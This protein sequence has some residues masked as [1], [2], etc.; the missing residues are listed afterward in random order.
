MLSA[1]VQE[2]L[3]VAVQEVQ[4]R[5]HELLTVEHILFSLTTVAPGR[6]LLEG[7]GA[8]VAV[9]REQLEGF[10]RNEMQVLPDQGEHEVHQTAGVQRV[11]ERALGHIHA[12]GRSQVELG[13]LFVAIL[14]EEDSYAHYFLTR[15]G[16]DR[17][18]ALTFISHGMPEGGGSRGV[19]PDA[20][21]EKEE[22]E[23]GENVLEKYATELTAR[24]RDGKIDPLV[25]RQEELDR[26]IEVLCRR[27]KNNPLF[28]G[29]P[30]VGK[31]AL[32]EGLALR[33]AQGQVPKKF[34]DVK[35]Y[36]LDMGLILAGTRYRGEFESRLKAIVEEL[37][38]IPDAV[39][40]ID[41]IHTIVGAGATS[42]GSM[43]ASNLLK[44]VLAS[45]EL[46][47]IGSTTHEEFRNHLEKDRALT[48]RFQRIDVGEPNA[49]DCFAI[50]NGLQ[51]HYAGHH[52]VRYSETV[53]RSIVDLSNRYVRDRLQP[54][55]AIDV[56]D[57]VGAA[58]DLRRK[59]EKRTA[60][61][62]VS[63]VERIVARMAGV[64]VRTVSGQERN[65]L[66]N[67]EKNLKQ[68]VF[69]QE[70]AVEQTV[71]AILRS[72]A[73]LGQRQRPTGA[74][75]F[76]G[77]TGV[78]KTE[79]ARGLAQTMGVEFLRYDMSEYME[80]H[81]VSRLI[82]SPPGY[83]GFD[84]GGLLTEAVRKA[85]YSVVLLDEIEKAHPD[86]FNILLQV[87]DYGTLTD[88]SGRKTDFSH[89]V[90]IMTSNAGTFE[91]S[92]AS[93]GFGKAAPEDAARKALGAVE[94][95]FTPEFR[96]R[97]D[98]MIPFRALTPAMM[99]RI[100]DK[101]LREIGNSLAEQQVTLASTPRAR[102]WLAEKGYDP[103]MGARPLRRLLR[104]RVEDALAGELLFGH[105]RHGGLVRLGVKDNELVLQFPDA[106]PAQG[107]EA[108]EG[109]DGRKDA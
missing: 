79:L 97:L 12:S 108:E 40:F 43:D 80:P 51:T 66:A 81:T 1:A 22:G 82:G 62:T 27:R 13:D 2:V 105:L 72:R 107:A 39:V 11:L 71:R 84:Q 6:L 67:L 41:E 32:A 98:A 48:R 18:D 16:V 95:L 47:C 55:K 57:E 3:K 65:R 9:L 75:L 60:A 89:T 92:K 59:D 45:G 52:R 37:K 83:V 34:K 69:G 63:D 49:E 20:A 56:M 53:L 96:N 86:I 70:E 91:M 26:A 36:A 44:P 109:D 29:D 19:A 38:N 24:A 77:P 15:Q 94:R 68:I 25:G 42:G 14:D 7:S 87:M 90:L 73:G 88:N 102:A 54:D 31:T 30:G 10:F 74:F 104:S 58:V 100:V 28:V 76:Y 33:I 23:A 103:A 46:R 99:Q 21:R 78:G 5:R 4:R 85:P 61:V 64:P 101:F 35:I 8:S 106:A 50:L 93:I 17:L